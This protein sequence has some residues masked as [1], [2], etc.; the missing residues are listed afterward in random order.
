MNY[1]NLLGEKCS[2]HK[3]LP[4]TIHLKHQ[5]NRSKPWK[6][7]H[8]DPHNRRCW[9][10]CCCR[11][12]HLWGSFCHHTAYYYNTP[13]QHVS[14]HINSPSKK[15]KKWEEKRRCQPTWHNACWQ[16]LVNFDPFF[17]LVPYVPRSSKMLRLFFL[18]VLR[19]FS[20]GGISGGIG[21]WNP[22]REIIHICHRH[23]IANKHHP[24]GGEEGRK[25]VR[26][27]RDKWPVLFLLSLIPHPRLTNCPSVRF[28]TTGRSHVKM[29]WKGWWW[30]YDPTHK[31][32]RGMR[33]PSSLPS[34]WWVEK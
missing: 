15:T 9:C 21:R 27:C 18:T 5:A 23:M 10:C 29:S 20:A 19:S 28:T 24:M 13:P 30:N 25:Y 7:H 33:R 1:D 17:F 6:C 12:A 11:P 4:S 32:T 16:F 31:H 22:H 26:V 34:G 3:L 8:L 14:A 2:Q